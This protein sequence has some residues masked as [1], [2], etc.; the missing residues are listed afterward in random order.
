MGNRRRFELIKK[1]LEKIIET[2]EANE[3]TKVSEIEE[4]KELRI[5]VGEKIQCIDLE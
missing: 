3:P 1:H 4:I 5:R 2:M